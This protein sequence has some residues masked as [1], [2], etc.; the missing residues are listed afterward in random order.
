MHWLLLS[1]SIVMEVAGTISMKHSHGFS[2]LI[3]SILIFVFYALAFITLTFTLQH[4]DLSLAYALWAGVGTAL[5][6][7][8]GVLH[9][10]EQMTVGQLCSIGLI[11]VGVVGLNAGGM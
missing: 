1:F 3:P 2:K 8:V 5:V 4:I 11:V 9:F 10:K 7:V 6:A